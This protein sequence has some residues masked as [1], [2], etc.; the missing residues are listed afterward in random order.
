M[1]DSMF[2]G[3]A[4]HVVFGLTYIPTIRSINLSMIVRSGLRAHHALI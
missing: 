1:Q 2:G 4:K 3:N